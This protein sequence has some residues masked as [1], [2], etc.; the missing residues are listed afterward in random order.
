MEKYRDANCPDLFFLFQINLVVY[1]PDMR[2]G[3]LLA[4]FLYIRVLVQPSK[5]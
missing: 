3:I 4:D 2:L 1:L 5:L